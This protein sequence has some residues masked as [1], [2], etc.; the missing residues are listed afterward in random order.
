VPTVLTATDLG[1]VCHRGQMH[2][3]LLEACGGAP[4]DAATCARCIREPAPFDG[5][6]AEVALKRLAVRAL[7]AVGGL[8]RVVTARDVEQRAAAVASALTRVQRVLAPTRAVAG[9]L[10]AA[11]LCDPEVLPYALD[12][13]PLRA[14]RAAPAGPA[15]VRGLGQL[16]PHKGPATLVRAAEL[17]AGRLGPDEVG[18]HLHGAASPGRHR[19]DARAL[20]TRARAAGVAVEPP[21]GPEAL[22]G[23]LADTAAVAIPSEWIENAPF[24]A[25]Q[26]RAA[27]VPVV[28]SDVPGLRE[29]ITEGQ[30]GWLVP[31]GDAA[32]LAERLEWLV[33]AG[34]RRMP[35]PGLPMSLAAHLS[36]L[37]R[38]YAELARAHTA[39]AVGAGAV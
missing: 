27:G 28:A 21:F 9:V 29:V 4:P 13:T 32:A 26:A 31:P 33:R 5:S 8:G 30:H 36:R 15:Q 3:W 2:D 35:Q 25:L 17:L 18:F 23:V 39:G 11:G 37:E 10:R 22:A 6:A 24:T 38:L 16:A 14:A 1:L 34:P 12:D 20:E 19:G 7:S